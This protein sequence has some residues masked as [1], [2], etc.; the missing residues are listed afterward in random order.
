MSASAQKGLFHKQNQIIPS[1]V[2]C[3]CHTNGI[4]QGS[5]SKTCSTSKFLRIL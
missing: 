3:D 1:T 2:L 4:F 5:Q